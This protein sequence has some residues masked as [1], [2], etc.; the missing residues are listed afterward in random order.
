METR[1]NAESI[2]LRNS[3][4][5]VDELSVPICILLTFIGLIKTFLDAQITVAEQSNQTMEYVFGDPNEYLQPYFDWRV[6]GEGIFKWAIIIV[7]VYVVSRILVQTFN[8]IARMLETEQAKIQM[9][10]ELKRDEK[11][12]EEKAHKEEIHID[13]EL[14]EDECKAVPGIII[15]EINKKCPICGTVQ[16]RDRTRCFECGRYFEDEIGE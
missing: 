5:R 9:S 12:D 13:K 10:S 15:D 2:A 14:L 16:R 11:V 4:R 1:S 7:V 8:V 6:F 3:A